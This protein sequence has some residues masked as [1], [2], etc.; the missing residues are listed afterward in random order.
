MSSVMSPKTALEIAA[1]IEAAE[2]KEITGLFVEESRDLLSDLDQLL[3]K[4]EK[5]PLDEIVVD[6]LFRKVHSVKGGAGAV[7]S[8]EA[9]ATLAHYFE[10]VLAIVKRDRWQPP[11]EALDIFLEAAD[12]CRTHLDHIASGIAPDFSITERTA[13]AIANLD[14]LKVAKETGGITH[15]TKSAQPKAEVAAVVAPAGAP[16]VA[17]VVAST[18][19]IAE[20]HVEDADEG[21]FVASDKLDSFMKLSGEMVVLKNTLATTLR[22]HDSRANSE[23]FDK[24]LNDFLH[25]L[26]KVTD[27]LQEQI[28]SVRKV[29]LDRA[30]SKLPRLVRQTA[31]DVEK[32]IDYQTNGFQLGVDKTIAKALSASL[33]HMVRNSIDHGIETPAKRVANGKNPEGRLSVSVKEAQGFIHVV[34]EDDGAGIDR[35]RVVRKALEKG[36]IDEARS[37]ALSDSEA[38]ELIFLPGFSTAEVVSAVSGRGV[39]MDVVRSS[40]LALNGRISIESKLGYGSKFILDIPIPKTVMVEQTVVAES[41]GTLIAIPLQSISRII[42]RDELSLLRLQGALTFQHDNHTIRLIDHRCLAPSRTRHEVETIIDEMVAQVGAPGAGSVIVLRDKNR[43]V[44]LIV[45]AIHDQLE[46]V[47]RPFDSVIQQIPGFR[48]TTTF[49]DDQIAYVVSTPEV[50]SISLGVSEDAA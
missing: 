3:L 36:L 9:L 25:A 33:T 49:G 37:K 45:D 50:I 39:G 17:S 38:F 12:L 7:P 29:T 31:K 43:N 32:K 1:D 42:P 15:L 35:E 44:G 11:A 22:D 5:V 20:T 13:A 10:S 24:K 41:K 18:G 27:S 40:I 48:G 26:N 21:V 34:V 2:L 46:A 4:L 28:M 6:L 14:A 8:G 19:A 16:V 30:L 23:K 47:V